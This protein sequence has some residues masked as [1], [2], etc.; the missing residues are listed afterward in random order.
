MEAKRIDTFNVKKKITRMKEYTYMLF[1]N[2]L[3]KESRRQHCVEELTNVWCH[4]LAQ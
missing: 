4:K 3:G 2:R 1:E